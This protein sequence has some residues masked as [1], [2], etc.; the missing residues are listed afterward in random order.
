MEA[1][2]VLELLAD[3]KA[4]GCVGTVKAMQRRSLHCSTYLPWPLP[5]T[6]RVEAQKRPTAK[7]WKASAQAL[8]G[9]LMPRLIPGEQLAEDVVVTPPL[10]AAAAL[11]PPPE[12]AC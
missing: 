10:A 11:V 8:T 9:M 12:T 3:Q 4:A 5:A 7:T 6:L 2:T 1:Q